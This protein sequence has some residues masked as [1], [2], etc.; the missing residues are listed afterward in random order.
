[1][2]DGALDLDEAATRRRRAR[3][4]PAGAAPD[5]S[6]RSSPAA[7]AGSARSPRC[8]FSDPA[9]R[10]GHALLHPCGFDLGQKLRPL[11]HLPL[12]RERVLVER[13]G[14]PPPRPLRAL[15]QLAEIA[16]RGPRR[17]QL[18]REKLRRALVACRC[19]L[20]ALR[21]RRVRKAQRLRGRRVQA[22]DLRVA[23]RD[24]ELELR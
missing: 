14:A 13:P 24:L 11:G 21:S 17:G 7:A 18:R 2:D 19:L 6:D 22:L 23:A 15:V 20:V 9:D 12:E 16:Q 1:V 4:E 8:E 3:V 5:A 10:V